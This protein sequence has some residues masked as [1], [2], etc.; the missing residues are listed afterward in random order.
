VN[1]LGAVGG[2]LLG[3]F[4]LLPRW[5][6]SGLALAVLAIYGAAALV[7]VALGAERRRGHALACVGLV[8]LAGAISPLTSDLK[9]PIHAVYY[10]GLRN[11]TWEEY[12]AVAER[13]RVLYDRQGFYGQ[14]AVGELDGFRLLK[15]NGKTDASNSPEDTTTQVLLGHL[16][17]L[18]HPAPREAL[19]IGLG[20]GF[21]LRTLTRYPSVARVTMVELD[22]LVVEAARGYF[23]QANG[24]ALDDSKVEVVINDGRNYLDA[25]SRRWDVIV[26]VPSNIWVAG[27]TGLFT[28][29]FYLAARA[30]LDP[31]GIVS[32]WLP[33]YEMETD[34]LRIALKTIASVFEH[35]AY[36][37]I[38]QADIILL[39]SDRP[40]APADG[41]AL[42]AR[43][44]LPGV[45][46][47]LRAVGVSP[48]VMPDV[49]AHPSAPPGGLEVFISRTEILNTDDRPVL[50]FRTA[51]NLYRFA[52][53]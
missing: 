38:H 5:G 34:D 51:R 3:E 27:V 19:L 44:G 53:E 11:K 10:H 24:G 35:V 32:Q 16:P 4:V 25:S 18:I 36:W 23:A 48:S 45:V 26:C 47:D 1:T 42:E 17:M 7:F 31:G 41:A 52:K 30:H 21:T 28:R 43:L 6:F 39:A 29:E 8:A 40:L 14:V 12:R 15:L 20:G 33:L 37:P 46:G 49:L 50:E 13:T 2:A 9:L 22:P